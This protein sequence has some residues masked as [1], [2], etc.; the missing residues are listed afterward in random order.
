MLA[1]EGSDDLVAAFL[2]IMEGKAARQA[3]EPAESNPYQPGTEQW[4]K[5]LEGWHADAVRSK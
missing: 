5:W 1:D 3:N 4:A 2:F